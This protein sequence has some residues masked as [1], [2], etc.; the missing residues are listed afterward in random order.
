MSV[1]A[2]FVK[3]IFFSFLGW[4]WESIY[5]TVKEKR[6]A[7]RGFL[8]GP[9]CPIYGFCVVTVIIFS[10]LLPCVFDPSE[11]V[12][13]Q[14]LICMFGSAVVEYVTSWGLEKRF[15]AR[16]WDYSDMPLN[17]N[18]RVCLPASVSFGVAGVL[19]IRYLIPAISGIEGH[20]SRE[21][22][23][24]FSIVFAAILGADIAL[25]EASLSTLLKT[26]EEYKSEFNLKA[27]ETYST[28]SKMPQNMEKVLTEKREVI[29]ENTED[30]MQKMVKYAERMSTAQKHILKNMILFVPRTGKES[31]VKL[32]QLRDYI[33]RMK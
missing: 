22:Y 10:K 29:I 18:G 15:S 5:C 25:T 26:I 23:E 9:V 33:K 13:I 11:P 2:L 12:Y 6:W 1:S 14:F 20:I 17:I 21:I 30:H 7:D 27:E 3:F 19:I 24:V 16:W 4:V 31:I 28:I 32:N 8:F